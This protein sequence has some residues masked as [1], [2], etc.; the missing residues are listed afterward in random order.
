[1]KLL[2]ASRDLAAR[3]RVEEAAERS[4]WS[5]VTARTGDL[6]RAVADHAPALVVIDLD[7]AGPSG[8]D[9]P[10]GAGVRAIGFF[11]HVDRPLAEAAQAAGV[12]AVP[13]GRF[14][15]TLPQLLEHAVDEKGDHM[16][17]RDRPAAPQQPEGG[18]EE[19]LDHKPDS[20]EE[21]HEGN[22]AESQEREPHEEDRRAR[23]SE[24]QEGE[25]DT[26]DK[27]A[28]GR[29]SEGQEKGR[30]AANR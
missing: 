6:S 30:G 24:G 25:V 12:E 1:M 8:L 13:R 2:L 21:S 9:A 29:Y 16:A 28:E 7:E 27:E 17:E 20:P 18:F 23:Y 11:S 26:P 14:W 22:F 3:A 15:R 4:G 10:A 5:L 19:G